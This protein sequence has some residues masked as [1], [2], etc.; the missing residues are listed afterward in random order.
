MNNILVIAYWMGATLFFSVWLNLFKKDN[1]L[2][3]QEKRLCWIILLIATLLWPI[4][5]PLSYLELL[6]GK[7]H[8]ASV[9][10]G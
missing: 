5:V 3:G 4:V 8:T 2:S 10:K 7:R 6:Q 9:G 1:H